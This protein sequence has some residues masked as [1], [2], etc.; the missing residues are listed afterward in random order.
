LKKAGIIGSGVA[1]LAISIRLA[2]R[3]YAVEVFEANEYVGGKL[4]EI[5]CGDYRFD[6]GPSLFTMPRFLEELFALAGRK[7]SDYCPYEKLDVITNYFYADGTRFK[8]YSEPGRFAEEVEAVLKVDRQI[9]KDHLRSSQKLYEAT[10]NLFLNHSLHRFQHFTLKDLLIAGANFR[11]LNLFSTM[12]HVNEQKLKQE[13]LVRYFDRFAT[14]NGSDPYQCPATLNV[15]PHLEHNVGAFFPA[16]GMIAITKALHRL[17]LEC[18]VRF[19]LG[20]PVAE[21]LVNNN[22]A[23]GLMSASGELHTFDRIVS[24]MDVVPTY[25]KL[26]PR[27]KHPEKILKQPRSSSALIFYWGIKK[28]FSELGLHN[29]LFSENYKA[30]FEHI[31]QERKIYHDPTVYI[32]I[33]SK[34]KKDDAPAGC[35]NWFVMINVPNNEGQDWDA[36]ID[37]SRKNILKKIS[38]MLGT[39]IDPLIESESVLDPRSIESRTSSFRGALYGSSSNNRMAAFLRHPNF[40][41]DI[42]GL[43]FCGGS[44]HPGGGIPL[45][46][47]SAKITDDVI[48]RV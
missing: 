8:S 45:C 38:R 4:S 35:E 26:L 48:P 15:I 18:G 32:N 44:V 24:N 19:H 6:A 3:G 21:I 29:I 42:K 13:K 14:Y 40:S 1:G 7:F 11:S 39:E 25:R 31:F 37:A 27:Q 41:G 22:H 34:Y 2:L 28:E 20:N 5:R 46:L 17:A 12:H 43:Y 36:W 10:F 30:E 33:T 16:G 9:V 47:L 23:V